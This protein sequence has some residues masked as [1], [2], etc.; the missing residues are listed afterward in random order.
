MKDYY[1]SNERKAWSIC[2]N[3]INASDR[4]E[5]VAGLTGLDRFTEELYNHCFQDVQAVLRIPL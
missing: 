1:N 5:I 3:L 4:Q 2:I